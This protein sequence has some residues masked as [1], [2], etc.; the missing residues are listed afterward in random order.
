MALLI[1][2]LFTDWLILCYC[3][4]GTDRSLLPCLRRYY[5]A[6][7]QWSVIAAGAS[8]VSF[9]FLFFF[10]YFTATQAPDL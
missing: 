10:P 7:C 5:E 3:Y 4:T 8:E 2:N 9:P 6:E 1:Q